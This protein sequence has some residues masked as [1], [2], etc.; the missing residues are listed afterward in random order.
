MPE[1][2]S[3]ISTPDTIFDGLP[4]MVKPPPAIG[5]TNGGRAVAGH[6]ATVTK[7][8]AILGT[9]SESV[10]EIV[11]PRTS[12]APSVAEN[13]TALIAASYS[14]SVPVPSSVRVKVSGS[15]VPRMGLSV[16]AV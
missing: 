16:G 11:S 1:S 10:A 4:P 3:T 2:P 14:A 8:G 7:P 15:Q 5:V 9:S 6:T 13:V 12:S